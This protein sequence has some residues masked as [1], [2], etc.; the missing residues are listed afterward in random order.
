LFLVDT[1]VGRMVVLRSSELFPSSYGCLTPISTIIN[2]ILQ[3]GFISEAN[4]NTWNFN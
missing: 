2:Y 4:R 3:I 1:T